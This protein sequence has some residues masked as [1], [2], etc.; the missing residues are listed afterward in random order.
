MKKLIITAILSSCILFVSQAQDKVTFKLNPVQG[1]VIPYEMIMKTDLEGPQNVI[2]DMNMNMSMTAT[3]VTDTEITYETKYSKV[4]TD[5]DAGL[6]IINYDS[7][8]EPAN[9][10]EEAF[11]SQMKPMLENTLTM[12]LDR[13]GKFLD[14][15]FPNVAAQAFDKSSL[16]GL[17]VSYPTKAISIGESWE[18]DI[19]LP[20]VQAIGK[21]INTYTEKLPQGYKITVKTNYVDASGNNIGSA[22]GY[23]IIDPNT[24]FTSYSTATTTLEMQGAKV[25]TSLELKE[26]K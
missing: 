21:T 15:Q 7:S 5:L 12:K 6:M 19:E 8:R 22:E 18:S 24:H 4:T 3:Q 9:Q 16:Q 17:A 1:K 25:S 14:M 23:Y 13:Q 11:A 26:I 2:M 20:Q 10:M